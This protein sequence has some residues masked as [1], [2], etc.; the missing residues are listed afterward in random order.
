MSSSTPERL[1]AAR[2]RRL[3]LVSA[4]ALGM[5]WWLAQEAPYAASLARWGL[6]LGWLSMPAVLALSLRLPAARFG[7]VFPATLLTGATG[8]L[9]IE[10][11]REG[12]ASF[13]GWGV[14]LTG[15]L[16]GDLLGAWLWFG[17]LP[18]PPRLRN[19][20][21]APRWLLIAV[22]VSLVL[23][24]IAYLLAAYAAVG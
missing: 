12:T 7:L 8:L 1:M 3:T 14:L 22:H 2:V 4:V 5:I 17:L 23:Y 18:V 15:I 19:P 16:V 10:A 6:A 21:S 11:W 9:A 24:G 13:F 20:G